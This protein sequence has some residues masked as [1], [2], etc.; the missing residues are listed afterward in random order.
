MRS[1]IWASSAS[2]EG[3]GRDFTGNVPESWFQ[4]PRMG[5][6]GGARAC[7]PGSAA[8]GDAAVPLTGGSA[9]AISF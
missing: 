5:D 4:V 1:C 9:P 7:P 8:G 2:V 6:D 3:V